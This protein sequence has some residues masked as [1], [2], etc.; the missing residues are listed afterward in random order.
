[1]NCAHLSLC[2]TYH[3]DTVLD[4]SLRQRTLIWRQRETIVHCA[5]HIVRTLCTVL[6]IATTPYTVLYIVRIPGYCSRY[7]SR[8]R[9]L[10]THCQVIAHCRH[11]Q[12][13]AHCWQNIRTL[14]TSLWHRNTVDTHY[15]TVHCGQMTLTPC[16][17]D[18]WSLHLALLT[19]DYDT[20]HCWQMIMTARTVDR[21]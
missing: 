1:M 9:A 20:V 3:E 18:R 11:C 15:D 14:W 10:W 13:T 12:C 16:T 7:L 4:I 8:H 5:W 2:W 17:V 6:G 21:W 19:D